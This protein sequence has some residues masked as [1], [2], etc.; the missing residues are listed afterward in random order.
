MQDITEKLKELFKERLLE[1]ESLAKHVNFRIGGP[2]KYFAEVKTINE[3]E[4]AT[5]I[6]REANIPIAVLGGGS[7]ILVNDSGFPGLVLK[8]SMRDVQILGTTVIAEAGA[9]SSA[10]A[11][12]TANVGLK[13]FEWAISLP[14][15]IGGAVRGNAG[16]FGGEMKDTVVS[17]DV[18]RD[19]KIVELTNKELTF[20]YRD[21]SVKHTDDIILRVTME[22]KIGD[23]DSLKK[24]LDETLEKRKCSQPLHSGSAGCMFKN[25]EIT[26]DIDLERLKKDADIPESMLT[27][28]RISAGWIIDQLGFKGKKIGNAMV[29]EEHGNFLINLGNA[30]ASDVAQLIALIKTEARDRFGIKLHEEV[31]YIGF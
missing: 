8:I 4:E 6:A 18:L 15:T 29:S 30:T 23:K 2:A 21:S 28:R 12:Q 14:G 7:N 16:C 27:A 22:L 26:S 17:V 5:N 1:N 24:A 20:G 13:G 3:L 9:I 31:Q 10:V 11:R 25:V 19:G